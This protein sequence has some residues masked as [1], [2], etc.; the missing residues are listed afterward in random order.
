MGLSL[1]LKIN[2]GKQ[3]VSNIR[4][5]LLGALLV[6]CFTH[7]FSDSAAGQ[8]GPGPEE[9][10]TNSATARFTIRGSDV[11][12]TVTSN[13]VAVNI[14]AV[15]DVD[16]FPSQFTEAK[17]G[18]RVTFTH[19]VVNTGNVTSDIT[20][21]GADV[22][23]DD[24][25]FA[26]F[27]LKL[28]NDNG[29]SQ[30]GQSL[31]LHLDPRESAEFDVSLALPDDLTPPLEANLLIRAETADQGASVQIRDSVR[32]ISGVDMVLRKGSNK[33]EATQNEGIDFT[34]NMDNQGDRTADGIP[35]TVNGQQQRLVML[36]DVIPAN[37]VFESAEV[38]GNFRILF[39]RFG[40]PL[41]EYQT[42]EPSELASIDAIAFGFVS[43]EPGRSESVRFNVR[44]NANASGSVFNQAEVFFNDGSIGTPDEEETVISNELEIPLNDFPSDIEFFEDDTFQQTTNNGVIG[45][46][47]FIQA[48]AA[49]CNLNPT[50]IDSAEIDLESALTGDIESF[51]AIENGRNTGLFN[52][53]PL[54]PTANG[55]DESVVQGND[56]LEI[57]RDDQV[58]ASLED[59]LSGGTTVRAEADILV[60]PSGQVFLSNN[61]RPVADVK[62]E[63]FRAEAFQNGKINTTA[64]TDPLETDF[65]NQQGEFEFTDVPRGQY[66]INVIP[67]E[68]FVFPSRVEPSRFPADKNVDDRG[69]FSEP[70][71]L[72]ADN[73]AINFDIPVDINTTG[74]LALSKQ[75]DQN[76]VET[77][78]FIDYTLRV[79]NQ[80][81]VGLT[82]L[83]VVDQIPFGFSFEEGTTT[84]NGERTEDPNI[85]QD[86]ILT[87][88][89]DSLEANEDM[90]IT[91]RLGVGP[92][93]VQG[94]GENRAV[95][96]ARSNGVIRSN[97][98]TERVQIGKGVFSD[99]GF[100][101]GAVYHDK[102]KNKFQ[103][104]GEP[105]I[106]GVR[107]YL[108]NGNYIIT[109]HEGRYS[110]QGLQPRKHIMKLDMS[111]LP[112]G[113]AL[114]ILDNRNAFD[115]SSRFVDLKKGELHRA[116]FAVCNCKGP[117]S[118]EIERRRKAAKESINT[119]EKEVQK[120]L[121]RRERAQLSDEERRRRA[122]SGVLNEESQV[123]YRGLADKKAN[124]PVGKNVPD[125]VVEERLQWTPVEIMIQDMDNTLG[126]VDLSDRDTL[127]YRT[128]DVR[129]KGRQ[130]ATFE[131]YRNGEEIPARRIGK[132]AS[133]DNIEVWNYVGVDFEAG[134][135]NL[136]VRMV[137]PFGNARDSASIQIQAPGK[138]ER[139][140]IEVPEKGIAANGTNVGKIKVSVFDEKDLKLN[141]RIPVTLSIDYG[142]FNVKDLD[143]KKPGVQQFVVDG[144]QEFE[145]IA[146]REA[147]D[148]QIIVKSGRLQAEN[149]ISFVPDLRDLIAAGIVE[150]TL[151]L[152]KGEI[153]EL[154]NNDSFEKELEEFSTQSDDLIADGRSAFF[155]KG[156]VLGKY[157]LTARYD[158]EQ[159]S[160]EE[161]FRDIQPDQ[162][163]PVYGDASV[164]GFDAQSTGPLFVKLEKNKSYAMYGDFQTQ[165]RNGARELGIYNRSQTGG[166]VNYETNNTKINAFGAD[167][168]SNQ[169]F[170]EFRALGTSGPFELKEEDILINSEQVDII[171]RD[172]DQPSVILNIERLQRFR[173]Y[174]IEP[175]TG[176][177]R[178]KSP[179]SSVDE[180]FNPQFIRIVYETETANNKYIVGGG[181]IQHKLT[182]NI[183]I[184]GNFISDNQP[185]DELQLGSSNVTVKLGENTR[186]TGEAAVTS[187][188]DV[189]E[190]V[191]GKVEMKH[192]SEFINGRIFAGKSDKRFD[193]PFAPL[194]QGR[195]EVGM[196]G[197]I[198]LPN[199][200]QLRVEGLHSASD[201][202][203]AVRQGGVIDLKRSLTNYLDGTL[204]VRYANNRSATQGGDDETETTNIRSRFD[205]RLPFLESVSL[206]AEAEQ[207]LTESGERLVAM[208]GDYQVSNRAKVFARHEFISSV[209]NSR[210]ALDE[211]RQRNRSIL[212]L[213]GQFLN[214]GSA[215]SE[216]RT[217]D[218][219]DGRNAVAA[220]GLRNNFDISQ[221]FGLQLNVERVFTVNGNPVNDGTSVGIGTDYTAAD[222]WKASARFEARFTDRG[223]TYLN[224]LGYGLRLNNEWSFL[225][226][227]LLSVE[228]QTGRRLSIRER[229]RGGFAFRDQTNHKFNALTRYEFKFEQE[230]AADI[231]PNRKVHI[232]SSHLNYH[233]NERTVLSGRV[234]NKFVD[235]NDR[236]IESSLATQLI[237][238]RL[239]YD[240]TSR[241]D[242]G[243]RAGALTSQG[244]DQN[245]FGAGAEVGLIVAKNLRLAA[246]YN[247]MG[248]RDEDFNENEFT[249]HGPHL[250]FS[251]KFTEYTLQNAMPRRKLN[252]APLLKCE[253]KCGQV[254]VKTIPF[255]EVP[256]TG[257]NPLKVEVRELQTTPYLP[258][259]I[260]FALDQSIITPKSADLSD[261]IAYYLRENMRFNVA[262]SAHTDSRSS[263]AYNRALAQRR[264]E[265]TMAYLVGA[266]IDTSRISIKPEGEQK[267]LIENEEHVVH[268]AE[269]RRV[270]FNIQPDSDLQNIRYINSFE[271]INIE[272]DEIPNYENWQNLFSTRF[273]LVPKYLPFPDESDQVSPWTES[274]LERI[275]GL[276]KRNKQY[277]IELSAFDTG[278]DLQENRI[279][280]LS[281]VLQ[282][283]GVDSNRINKRIIK[284]PDGVTK[285]R[286]ARVLVTILPDGS[287]EYTYKVPDTNLKNFEAVPGLQRLNQLIANSENW[288][289]LD[290]E[291]VHLPAVPKAVHFEYADFKLDHKSAGMLARVGK[292]LQ[293]HPDAILEIRG[294]SGGINRLG[295]ASTI[296]DKRAQTVFR[297]L[298]EWG[299]E[300]ERLT[301]KNDH[302]EVLELQQDWRNNAK[303]RKV[304]FEL[305]NVDNAMVEYVD[306]EFDVK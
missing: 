271:D 189:G 201:T 99:R 109:D 39:H 136:K 43:F 44:T 158:S 235:E 153:D 75:A 215:Y 6:V 147:G 242:V 270:E 27:F 146:P 60:N 121:N 22:S 177:I 80:V 168:G 173:D 5:W 185:T 49:G 180:N 218:V 306:Q 253:D 120:Q 266:G 224:T 137:D 234:A 286:F 250:G 199:K 21:T 220:I 13:E 89:L 3:L 65:T 125:S 188:T 50:L 303:L 93:A 194:A 219:I 195:T 178:F 1:F 119:L 283:H 302:D 246:G 106:P 57:V 208:G 32:V 126:F 254:S 58:I 122:S 78:D 61:N 117:V 107:L 198:K 187:R 31:Q 108:E 81:A 205:S 47:L 18:Q 206:F 101:I 8:N 129:V 79:T 280:T 54:V 37:T 232:F 112:E 169:I 238:S 174:I 191:A 90:E 223:N 241:F 9:R 92:A 144:E 142:K 154:D 203:D 263:Q 124:N 7:G 268:E 200:M 222:N 297:F 96:T 114:E 141:H 276:M 102:N 42:T 34:L 152:R 135:N 148:G 82:E 164:K 287:V 52:I 165:E 16:L 248:Y 299:I 84:I 104:P 257:I 86:G 305:K 33:Q 281:G 251:Y 123:D 228:D 24:F 15:E 2:Y 304:T 291:E 275:A 69:S 55:E 170:E 162:F 160:E 110:M 272:V 66:V 159:D 229:L 239:T 167:A 97:E 115:P 133:L 296:A 197:N 71:E 249:E 196:R 175:F 217:R 209:E 26:D 35:V 161:L 130:G 290:I 95:A 45:E 88:E 260:H 211:R 181:G 282:N 127:L 294:Y 230:G 278:T 56:T 204:G 243:A 301:V 41:H 138:P 226:K 192:D 259:K 184:G 240:I 73:N 245:D 213:E 111:T 23:D 46:P 202:S 83:A 236:S 300:S 29:Q 64:A 11:E 186:I 183:E 63:L 264:A 216:Y 244:F 10:I 20:L 265:A 74:A 214:N 105:G 19:T 295:K 227:N 255:S 163:Y 140:E 149:T 269:N 116:D 70:F 171:T 4:I 293:E 274:A 298:N 59:C 139:L 190:G 40:D 156:K 176:E 113:A 172:R 53:R 38:N 207:S 131:L 267:L 28:T 94:D 100:I 221:G 51:V 157:L 277:Q 12:R 85:G 262:L 237:Q 150:G 279:D 87:F 25:D 252:V 132:K 76:R 145:V 292:F 212:G 284:A 98:A 77:G 289:L 261:R 48:D 14:Q 179:I 231:G 67:P 103:D 30:Q 17:S 247:V 118:Q 36:R 256:L 151:R 91:Y 62:V 233:I 225:V 134:A 155:I 210:F 68:E 166:K 258:Q 128:V 182:D 288:K 285:E 273:K 72:T 143:D 193:N